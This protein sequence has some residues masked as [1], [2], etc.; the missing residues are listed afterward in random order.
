MT[1]NKTTAIDRVLADPWAITAEQLRVIC[2]IA[3]QSART[4]PRQ[5]AAQLGRPLGNQRH[6]TL[7]D[8]VATLALEGSLFAKANA[9]TEHSGA[10]SYEIFA[11]DLRD[12]LADD[13]VRA[14]V[15]AVD[16]PGGQVNGAS[17]L[18]TMVYEARKRKP[19][20][21]FIA[22][23]GASA[24]YWVA[25][26]ASEVYA[27]DTAQVGSVGIVAAVGA[28]ADDEGVYKF[29]SSQTPAKNR[30]VATPEGADAVQRNVDA[31]AEVF[32]DALA[33]YRSRPRSIIE[34]K[35]GSGD[36]FIGRDALARGMVDGI[37]TLEALHAKLRTAG[38]GGKRK[39]MQWDEI[40]AESLAEHRPD[41]VAE[42][43]AG[44]AEQAIEAERARVSH[45]TAMT[46]GLGINAD[47][48]AELI[49]AGASVVDAQAKVLEAL[50]ERVR[51]EAAEAAKA[52][53]APAEPTP[54]QRHAAALASTEANLDAPTPGADAHLATEPSE[55]DE[56]V[57]VAK[58]TG[59][60]K[61]G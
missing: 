60:I 48:V 18:A 25:A 45:I 58:T 12:A 26:A 61:N 53:A 17:E 57:R 15:I 56:L 23:M 28:A 4:P 21:A 40:T 35:Y 27:A 50:S 38:Q 20:V 47:A 11:N 55:L 52:P 10:T 3:D 24:A 31:L 36:V 59:A 14:I 39:K 43:R 34:T 33:L 37:T 51:S 22:G 19:V 1:T 41:I 44:L 9:M 5:L 46:D 32:L 7:R 6:A 49:S 16:S 8:G 29:V 30:S 2:G 54:A 42:L 13:S